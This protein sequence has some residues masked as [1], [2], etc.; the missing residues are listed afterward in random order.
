MTLTDRI[1]Q[2]NSKKKEELVSSTVR[3]SVE[4]NSMVE[5]L[6]EHLSISK[7][8]MFIEL[9]KEGLDI[10]NKALDIDAISDENSNHKQINYH[11]FNT[12][13]RYNSSDGVRMLKEQIVSA[14]YK[15]WK[16][17]INKINKDD[18]VFLYENGVGIIA[19]GKASGQLIV[20]DRDGDKDEMHYQKLND[21]II[22]EKPIKAS[23]IKEIL[24]TQLVF[25]RTRTYLSDGELVLNFI[26][27]LGLGNKPQIK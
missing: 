7:Q 12:N 24:N 3:L 14:F 22:L 5:E 26:Q 1:K 20:T 27:S 13:K 11:L 4:M 18:I 2:S 9:I 10:A 6:A 23:K 16:F 21:F 17:E 8:K 15:P 19:Y 25:M